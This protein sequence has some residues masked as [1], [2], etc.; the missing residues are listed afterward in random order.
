MDLDFLQDYCD[1]LFRCQS[2]PLTGGNLVQGASWDLIIWFVVLG[3][4]F[5]VVHATLKAL[6]ARRVRGAH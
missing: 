4:A 3:F 1:V 2:D 6:T 5:I